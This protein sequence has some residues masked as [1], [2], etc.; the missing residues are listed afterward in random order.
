ML[1]CTGRPVR[2]NSH[3]HTHAHT[4]HTTHIRT[5]IRTNAEGALFVMLN[6]HRRDV[7][8]IQIYICDRCHIHMDPFSGIMKMRVPGI[9][10]DTHNVDE[11]I[12]PL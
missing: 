5:H 9:S 6:Q 12:F 1:Q 8:Y 7:S 4:T 11:T 2:T 3:I 10:F